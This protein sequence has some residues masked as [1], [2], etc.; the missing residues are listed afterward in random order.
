MARVHADDNPVPSE[1]VMDVGSQVSS[2]TV[3]YGEK[4]GKKLSGYLA[5]PGKDSMNLPRLLVI[6]EWW[7]L[8]DNMRSMA[9]QLASEGYVALAVDLYG[10]SVAQTPA[11]ARIMM[12]EV[13]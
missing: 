3:V 1:M 2:K 8:N 6:H 13:G 9:D 12:S 10:G 5:T 11:E 4:D 7:G